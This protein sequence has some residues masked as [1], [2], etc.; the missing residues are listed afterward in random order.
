MKRNDQLLDR[1]EDS[2]KR[3]KLEFDIFFNGGSDHFPQKL[4]EQMDWEI[5]RLY[6]IR[7]LT[8]AQ[9]FRLN[10]LATRFR[11]Y[12]DLWQRNLRLL[13]QGRKPAYGVRPEPENARRIE[14]PIFSEGDQESIDIL[15]QAFC[16]ARE[17][18]GN[19]APIDPLKF[20]DFVAGKLRAAKAEVVFI[21]STEDGDVHL[22]TRVIK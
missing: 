18:T 15:F 17:R 12:N 21:V 9:S 16:R 1:L 3:L 22:K 19:E 7:A 13:E 6:N 11:V 8:Y 5:K 2:I 20:N 14:V 10:T 4:H